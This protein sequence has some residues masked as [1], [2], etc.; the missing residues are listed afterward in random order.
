MQQT[1]CQACRLHECK[2]LHKAHVQAMIASITEPGNGALYGQST[3]KYAH[4]SALQG[5]DTCALSMSLRRD[6]HSGDCA[7]VRYNKEVSIIS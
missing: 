4:E 2:C 3:D 6:V 1:G 5:P 7:A